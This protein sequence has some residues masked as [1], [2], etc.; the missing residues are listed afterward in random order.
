MQK[1]D[2]YNYERTMICAFFYIRSP[3]FSASTFQDKHIIID[4]LVAKTES[5][6]QT[7][8]EEQ[9]WDDIINTPRVRRNLRRLAAEARGQ[10]TAGETEEG[11]F[12]VE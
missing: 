6:P 9:Q 11:G 12:G 1:K 4:P 2:L 8:S 3:F 7:V 5:M 10:F